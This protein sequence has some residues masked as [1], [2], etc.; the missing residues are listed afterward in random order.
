MDRQRSVVT[1]VTRQLLTGKDG[2]THDLG[3]WSWALS[4][5]T[6]IAAGVANW[7]NK[8]QID[9]AAL[10]EALGI[11]AGAHGLALWAKRD[12]EPPPSMEKETKS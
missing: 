11:V 8:G 7:W 1:A 6:V 2:I 5:A 10:G 9:L 3:R 4:M 12:V